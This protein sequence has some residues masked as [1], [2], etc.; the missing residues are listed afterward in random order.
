MSRPQGGTEGFLDASTLLALPPRSARPRCAR[1]RRQLPLKGEAKLM[2]DPISIPL[3]LLILI[4]IFAAWA[5]LDRLLVPSVRWFIR[6]RVNRVLDELGTRLDVKIPEFT[7]T[8]R[9]VLVDRLVHD[10]AVQAAAAQ[11]AAE[12]NM[13]G[14][15]ATATVARYAREIVPAFNAYFYFR[16][17]YALA[18]R[19]SRAFYRV[20]MGHADDE[21]LRRIGANSTPVFVIN[22]RSNFDY[23]LVAFLAMERTALSYAVGEW[24]RIWPL[25]SLI[26]LMGGFFVRRNSRNPLYRRVLERYVQMATE[27]GVPQAIFPEGGLSRDGRL[28]EPRLGLLDYILRGFDPAG[29]RDV[30]FIP[31]GINYDR[32]VEDRTLLLS[33]DPEAPPRSKLFVLGTTAKFL[34]HQLGLALRGRWISGYACVNFGSPISLKAYIAERGI[35]LRRLSPEARI[36]RVKALAQDLIAAVSRVVP[37]LPV[38]LVAAV[39]RR[40][41]TLLLDAADVKAAALDIMSELDRAGAITYL[42]RSDRDYAIALGLEMLKI[43]HLVEEE[44]GLLRINEA[45]RHVLDYYAN[46]IEHLLPSTADE[47]AAPIAV[48]S[49]DA[50]TPPL[51]AS[52]AARG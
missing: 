36:E 24:A 48:A 47:P 28:R 4:A 50:A 26:K 40:R 20:R 19:V 9:Q 52:A 21:G 44:D 11:Y 14:A 35:D 10:R 2:G 6:R 49:P 17:G 29:E 22:H 18:R 41:G 23:V 45:N 39:F 42:P 37:V 25:Q 34:L 3:W 16:V 15:V 1:T 51:P 8:K 38:P 33:L 30:A 32:V 13:P 27:G 7:L 5:A 43:R 12:N 31:V 46:S